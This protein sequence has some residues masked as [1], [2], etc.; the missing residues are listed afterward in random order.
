MWVPVSGE[1]LRLSDIFNHDARRAVEN[2][3]SKVLTV[4]P[5]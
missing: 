4:E 3:K 1:R 5:R 2:D